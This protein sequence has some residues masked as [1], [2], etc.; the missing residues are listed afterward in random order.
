VTRAKSN[1]HLGLGAENVR[2]TRDEL[3][4]LAEA[5]L[6]WLFRLAARQSSF[7]LICET[8]KSQARAV[9]AIYVSDGL[10]QE[11]EAMHAPSVMNRF[12]TS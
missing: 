4:T 3:L 11:F 12:F 1:K 8:A 2:R 10:T 9:N 7:L 5:S 6:A